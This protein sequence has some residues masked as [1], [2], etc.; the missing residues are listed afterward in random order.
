VVYLFNIAS[1]VLPL[2]LPK[3]V[4]APPA[5]EPDSPCDFPDCINTIT[6]IDKA[7]IICKIF[8]I[9]APMPK[10]TPPITKV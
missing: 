2:F 8:K 5:M 6:I 9:N 4:S 3:K 1:I 7:I 10:K